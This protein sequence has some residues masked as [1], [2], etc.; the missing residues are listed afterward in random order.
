MPVSCTYH[1]G[2][3]AAHTCSRCRANFCP[4]CIIVKKSEVSGVKK[5][6]YLCPK[7]NI[8]TEPIPFTDRIEPFW[9]R[10]PQIFQYPLHLHPVILILVLSVLQIA[11]AGFS[12][13]GLIV[14][15]VCM[16]VLLTYANLALY[17]SSHGNPRPPD[18][19]LQKI[20]AN[21]SIVFKQMAIYIIFIVL[22]YK[23]ATLLFPLIG[24][25]ATVGVMAFYI[26]ALMFL[27][28]AMIIMLAVTKSLIAAILPHVFIR[29]AWRIGWPYLALCF[30]L[31]LLSLAPAAAAN[32]LS[33]IIPPKGLWPILTILSSYYMI[34]SYHL[35]G[36]ILFQYH[37]KV[38]Y[39]VDFDGEQDAASANRDAKSPAAPVDDEKK[40]LLSRV[41]IFI[42]DGDYNSAMTLIERDTEGHDM[43]PVIAERYYNLLKLTERSQDLPSFGRYYLRMIQGSNTTEKMAQ[44]FLDCRKTDPGFVSDDADLLYLAAKSLNETG[45]FQPSIAAFLEF[46]ERYPEH[47]MIP[48][49]YFFTAKLLHE[50]LNNGR[51]ASRIL[52]HL[53]SKYPFH[54]NTA[55]VQS[56]LRQINNGLKTA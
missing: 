34:V 42:K 20:S 47:P 40:Q 38:G 46:I 10:F 55:F 36:Y 33:A 26:L 18:F 31:L 27:L 16:G 13:L 32:F 56:Y 24:P 2:E 22:G 49:A 14:Q 21:F 1:P 7:C 9:K 30:F 37:E 4:S 15:L 54:E 11:F 41:N 48:N 12:L 19:A 39:K 5:N 23:I 52:Q 44:V 3:N 28:P 17:A 45:N 53:I 29:L 6:Y 43:D 8:Y 51:Q 50:K 25:E 35:M